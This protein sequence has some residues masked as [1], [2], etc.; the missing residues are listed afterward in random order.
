MSLSKILFVLHLPPPVHGASMM[1]KY[2]HDSRLVNESFDCRFINLSASANVDEV[3]K[4]SL[5]KVIFLLTNLWEVI[6]VVIR[7]RPTLVYLTPTSGGW[8][9]YRDF[10]MVKILLLLRVKLVMHFHNKASKEWVEKK[11]NL[12]L[13]KSFFKGVKIILLDELLYAERAPFISKNKV[14]FCPNGIPSVA[15]VECLVRLE[16]SKVHFL[17]LSNM[18]EGKGVFVLLEAC[19]VLMRS[20]LGFQCDFV[21]GWKDVSEVAFQSK[22][23]EYGLQDQV[24]AHGA[25]YGDDKVHFLQKADV[26]IFPTHYQGETFGLVLLEAMDYSLPCISTDNGAIKTVIMDG[27]SGYCIEQRNV[28]AL[29]EKMT[30]MIEHPGERVAMGLN[31]KKRF[32]ENFTLMHFETKIVSILSDCVKYSFA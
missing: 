2:I 24:K 28:A 23:V 32:G 8:G 19:L 13:T 15:P 20:G 17:F 3:G 14:F 31:G 22:I 9:F 26:F 16:N 18:M 5:R 21:G 1:G 11:W 7:E 25:K 29:A 6:G 12:F 4:L 30:W 10:I 27:E